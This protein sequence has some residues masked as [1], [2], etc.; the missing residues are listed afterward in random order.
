MK[1][2]N[3]PGHLTHHQSCCI[4]MLVCLSTIIVSYTCN[5]IILAISIFRGLN[6]LSHSWTSHCQ[7]LIRY[8]CTYTKCSIFD[9]SNVHDRELHLIVAI[10]R[11]LTL[12]HA[13][14][15]LRSALKNMYQKMYL[16]MIISSSVQTVVEKVSLWNLWV[17]SWDPVLP[18]S[19]KA[20]S[21]ALTNCGRV[22]SSLQDCV[23]SIYFSIITWKAHNSTQCGR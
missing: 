17:L 9:N 5:A 14:K 20:M 15:R 18:C 6:L 13:V 12:L 4:W 7:Y 1:Q 23:K 3:N 22:T 19:S 11:S 21:W 2:L 8:L 16:I 10:Q